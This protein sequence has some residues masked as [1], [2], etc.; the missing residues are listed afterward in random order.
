MDF[1]SLKRINERNYFYKI[2]FSHTTTYIK[3]NKIFNV[4]EK[5]YKTKFQLIQISQTTFIIIF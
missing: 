4:R 5:L 1:Y 3:P 2:L